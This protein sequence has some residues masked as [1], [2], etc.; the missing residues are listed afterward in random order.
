MDA[1]RS[2]QNAW[3]DV[4][5]RQGGV[6]T[7]LETLYRPFH[8]PESHFNAEYDP[9]L[10][11]KAQHLKSS[12]I[13]LE[14]DLQQE[15]SWIQSKLLQPAMDAK[16]SC[17]PVKKLIKQRENCKLDFER[18]QSRVDHAKA[19]ANRSARDETALIKH[20]SDLSQATTVCHHDSISRDP[21]LIDHCSFT[22]LKM[23]R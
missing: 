13:D 21:H 22:T 8:D 20:E 11:A 6:A 4:L 14:K 5:K 1:V 3:N 18:Y 19:K 2:F 15:T 7:C 12:Y 23:T 17:V 16:Q 10:L 9:A